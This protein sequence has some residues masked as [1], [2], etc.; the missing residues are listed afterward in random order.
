MN[1]RDTIQYRRLSEEL[2]R[3]VDDRVAIM[4]EIDSRLGRR[5]YLG[6][7]AS[8]RSL[9]KECAAW[10]PGRRGFS[11]ASLQRLWSRWHESDHDWMELIDRSQAG[12]AWYRHAPPPPSVPGMFLD[13]LRE[14]IKGANAQ[15]AVREVVAQWRRWH[16]G[17]TTAALPGYENPPDPDPVTGIPTGWSY[18]NLL[19]RLG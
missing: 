16:A 13:Y 12:P 1:Y 14:R 8:V 2:Q 15:R 18:A 10:W 4:M 9:A 7:T 6:K 3:T 17:D 11:A 5:S 19:R